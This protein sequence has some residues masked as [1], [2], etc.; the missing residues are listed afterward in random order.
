MPPDF[1]FQIDDKVVL[2]NTCET[3]LC[4]NKTCFTVIDVEH[5]ISEHITI[6]TV[7]PIRYVKDNI[8]NLKK[9]K[10]SEKQSSFANKKKF[11]KKPSKQA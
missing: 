3:D 2:L 1:V 10:I 4:T 7:Q 5:I 6:I 8:Y 11:T 9:K